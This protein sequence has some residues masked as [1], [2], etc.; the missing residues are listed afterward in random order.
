M[1]DISKPTLSFNAQKNLWRLEAVVNG[2][3]VYF[4]SGHELAQSTEAFLCAFFVHS[5]ARNQKMRI[6]GAVDHTLAASFDALS[7]TIERFWGFK[8]PTPEVETFHGERHSDDVGMFFTCGV[9][10]FYTLTKKY[11]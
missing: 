6:A 5:K 7:E 2:H 1:I 11:Q 8:G 9:D 4:Q 3:P 10:S